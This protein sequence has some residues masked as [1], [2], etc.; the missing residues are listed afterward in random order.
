MEE[1]IKI[2]LSN[3]LGTDK[4]AISENT[5]VNTVEAWDSLRHMQLIIALEE[6]F[7]IDFDGEIISNMTSYPN[8]LNYVKKKCFKGVDNE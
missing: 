1:R 5:S 8:I 2:I 4:T 3:V 7:N 6:E